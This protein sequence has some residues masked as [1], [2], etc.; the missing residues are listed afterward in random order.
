LAI[1]NPQDVYAI[2]RM[3]PADANVWH[4]RVKRVSDGQERA[5]SESQILRVMVEDA[6]VASLFRVF[7]R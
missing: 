4:Y 5:V 2:S 1:N 6:A 7:P 3:L